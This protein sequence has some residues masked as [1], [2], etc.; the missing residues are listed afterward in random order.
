MSKALLEQDQPPVTRAAAASYLA[1]FVSRAEFIDREGARRVTSILCTF[2][3]NHLDAFDAM[4]HSGTAALSMAQHDVFYAVTQ[5]VFL[6][7]CFRWRDLEE[8]LEDMDELIG[9]NSRKKWMSELEIMQRVVAS[10]LNPLKV[11]NQIIDVS[12]RGLKCSIG[13]LHQCRHPVRQSGSCYRFRVLLFDP[14]RQQAIRI[15]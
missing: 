13:V 15:Q 6:I 10:P 14:E 2:L 11:S 8:E 1:S 12:G 7:F 9:T 3:R 5:A 4:S